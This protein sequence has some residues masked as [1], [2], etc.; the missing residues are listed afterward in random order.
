M[1]LKLSESGGGGEF[2]TS[3]LSLFDNPKKINA[4]ISTK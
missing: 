3:L 4:Q 2:A 1:S